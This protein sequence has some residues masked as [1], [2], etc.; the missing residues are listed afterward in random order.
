[1]LN[2]SRL[3]GAPA[4]PEEDLRYGAG[5]HEAR[6][7][8]LLGRG[9]VV[10]WNWTQSCN[11]ACTHCYADAV[12]GRARGE[13]DTGQARALLHELAAFRVPALLL[14]GG[15]PLMRG[16]ALELVGDARR[17]GLRCTLSTNGTLI[18]DATAA[19]LAAAGITYV[20]VSLDGP[21]DVH[22]RWRG[23]RG[24]HAATVD[25]I[26]RLRARGVRVGLRFTLH[27]G[28][29]PHLP[30]MLETA[31]TLGIGRVCVYHLV[32]AGR[33]RGL[34]GSALGREEEREGLAWLLA[35]AVQLVRSGTDIEP[36]T[37]DIHSDGPFTYLWL[38]RHHPELA[39]AA[40]ELLRRNRG[41]RSGIALAA[42]GPRGDV[43]PDQFSRDQVLGNVLVRRLQ[44]IWDGPDAAP[45]LGRL[46]DRRRYIG[47]RCATCA[48]F[49]VCG[50]NLRARAAAAGN[51]WGEDPACLLEDAEVAGT[52]EAG[53]PTSP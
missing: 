36:L 22:D 38:R 43:Y 29:A 50:G 3:V 17:L 5:V 51:L 23:R 10:V 30:H 4:P 27:R 26:R 52:G 20:G 28:S 41:N 53:P 8:A 40:W 24:A 42:I 39:P 12:Q 46:R 32:P 19:A 47:G 34:G 2:L 48:W 1:M 16:D 7:G 13:L 35:Q 49:P 18:D 14:S 25:G 21:P 37:L 33:G 45:L 15:E 6:T 44:D 9:P 11:L 31:I